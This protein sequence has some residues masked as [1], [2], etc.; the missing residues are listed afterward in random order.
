LDG[1]N[2]LA[3]G[4]G[5]VLE[6]V[7]VMKVE[8]DVGGILSEGLADLDGHFGVTAAFSLSKRES[9]TRETPIWAAKAVTVMRISASA[10]RMMRP[11]WGGLCMRMVCSSL[12]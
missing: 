4:F 7:I 3:V 11:G 6:V 2:L 8:R 12:G 10:S 5:G 1:L 9:A